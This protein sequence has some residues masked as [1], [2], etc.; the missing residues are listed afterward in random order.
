MKK[1]ILF[2]TSLFLIISSNIIFSQITVKADN[3]I[4][5]QVSFNGRP[6]TLNRLE[7]KE[8]QMSPV[9]QN[10]EWKFTTADIQT[11][12]N[13]RN[14]SNDFVE[15]RFYYLNKVDIQ[16]KNIQIIMEP[17]PVSITE[18][19]HGSRSGLTLWNF[20]RTH[21]NWSTGG[22]VWAD[23]MSYNEKY[24][25]LDFKVSPSRTGDAIAGDDN[26]TSRTIWGWQTTTGLKD[27]NITIRVIVTAKLGTEEPINVSLEGKD[28]NNNGTKI[29]LKSN[30]AVVGNNYSLLIDPCK[31]ISYD[32][33]E[34]VFTSNYRFK[35]YGINIRT[36][37]N[38]I[39]TPLVPVSL[40]LP[41]WQ[42]ADFDNMLLA[43]I[44]NAD[45]LSNI[46]ELDR[47]DNSNL[48]KLLGLLIN[49]VSTSNFSY[50]NKTGGYNLSTDKLKVFIICEFNETINKP[51]QE[52]D[53]YVVYFNSEG[54]NNIANQTIVNGGKSTKPKDP[55]RYGYTFNGWYIKNSKWDFNTAVTNDITLTAKW[56]A[57]IVNTAKPYETTVISNITTQKITQSIN[58]TTDVKATQ[59]IEQNT[60]TEMA[61][62]PVYATNTDSTKETVY[63]TAPIETQK[64]ETQ[65]PEETIKQN[66][67]QNPGSKTGND[68]NILEIIFIILV[69][70]TILIIIFWIL[71]VK[72]WI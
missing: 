66:E 45:A 40:F 28:E 55:I 7:I 39:F 20:A 60:I 6:G 3:E 37:D 4:A 21:T 23:I 32:K 27:K 54:G 62:E 46:L 14:S 48:N 30:S 9:W 44:D 63:S 36:D 70:V 25:C 18:W 31:E 58:L 56:T 19:D 38:K 64:I 65:K 17:N 1:I 49:P 67:S 69:S 16:V 10:Y 15:F 13:G 22:N 24:E 26:G 8:S 34:D 35:I 61:T 12:L 42:N 71:K 5:F 51:N 68:S 29:M 43:S 2:L 57:N 47:L 72:Q 41:A 33:K 53:K 11:Y 52:K 50:D 59:S